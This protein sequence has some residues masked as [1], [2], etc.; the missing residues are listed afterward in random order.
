MSRNLMWEDASIYN[1]QALCSVNL[2][3]GSH[4]TGLL[5]LAN[6]SSSDWVIESLTLISDEL[7]QVCILNKVRI[8][9]ARPENVLLGLVG[10]VVVG[11]VEVRLES[12]GATN[13]E[14]KAET[15]N[16]NFHIVGV[17]E[18]IRFDDSFVVWVDGFQINTSQ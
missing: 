15:L 13:T 6:P 4:H 9:I 12:R 7:F 11:E 10:V 8:S 14:G 1:S 2:K 18:I 17:S 5:I 3:C 16:E